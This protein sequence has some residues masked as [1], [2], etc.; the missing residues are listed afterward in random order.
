MKNNGIVVRS[1]RLGLN[2]TNLK[3]LNTKLKILLNSYICHHNLGH[4]KKSLKREETLLMMNID[5]GYDDDD[6]IDGIVFRT[7]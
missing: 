3:N 5:N 6:V 1:S 7:K 4:H 2:Y